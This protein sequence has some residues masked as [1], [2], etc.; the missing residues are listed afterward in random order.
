MLS[1]HQNIQRNIANFKYCDDPLADAFQGPR[2]KNVSP[3]CKEGAGQGR[4]RWVRVVKTVV[5]LLLVWLLDLQLWLCPL[6]VKD[7]RP[8]LHLNEVV[9]RTDSGEIA[10]TTICGPAIKSTGI[11]D[12]N[13]LAASPD[14]TP[15]AF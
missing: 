12:P 5:S 4:C 15:V 10:G 9:Q 6:H 13:T 14:F 8:I 1:M 11:S 2:W 3:Q 7:R